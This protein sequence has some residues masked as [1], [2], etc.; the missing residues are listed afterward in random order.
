MVKPGQVFEV[1]LSGEGR[2]ILTRLA[3][4][5]RPVIKLV[6]KHGYTVAVGCQPL[7]QEQVRTF[8]DEFP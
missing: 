4:Q 7:T 2:I 5:G 3:P 1:Q 8:L 6:K